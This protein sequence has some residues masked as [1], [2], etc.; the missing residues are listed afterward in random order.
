[1]KG[2]R[3]EWTEAY[4]F[5]K[6]LADGKLHSAD[7][8]LELISGAFFP[9]IAILRQEQEKNKSQRNRNY[10][11]LSQEIAVVDPDT[12]ETITKVPVTKF[13]EQ[14][15]LLLGHI[16]SA[17]G[18]SFEFED[19]EQFLS[20]IDISTLKSSSGDKSDIRIKL[21]D[22]Y[23]GL[24][25]ELGFSIKSLMGKKAT[26]FNA[27]TG[28]NFIYKVTH[29]DNKKLDLD[30]FNRETYQ[31]SIEGKK[32]AKISVR[33][34]E[35][36]AQGFRCDFVRTQSETFQ[37]N[38]TMIDSLLP[39]ILS[40]LLQYRYLNNIS[41]I[42]ELIELL[43]Q[44]NPL[45]FDLTDKHGFYEYKLK[46][47][48]SDCALGMTPETVWK[49]KYD[50]TGGIIVAKPSGDLACY[51]VYNKNEF[52]EYLI[53]VTRLEQPETSECKV[54]PGQVEEDPNKPFQFGWVYEENSEN[55]IKLNL[56]VRYK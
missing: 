44:H 52:D 33:L 7:D 21:H 56:Q 35:L 42:Q 27:G 43:D 6:L 17:K 47:F 24:K 26:L 45:K 51:H 49:G 25:P 48:L 54:N 12:D 40:Y 22:T 41:K 19:V 29:P 8:Q 36:Q 53:K 11:V 2:N 23:T 5:L 28:T 31:K 4:V 9:I 46:R 39:E 13:V 50:A 3:G 18:R 37:R 10:N 15:K 34:K 14:A 1:M 30:T 32:P 16:S 20:E 55:F 38:L